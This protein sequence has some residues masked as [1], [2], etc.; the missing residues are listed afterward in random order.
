[1]LAAKLLAVEQHGLGH[2]FELFKLDLRRRRGWKGSAREAEARRVAAPA[3]A[4]WARLLLARGTHIAKSLGLARHAVADQLH[5]DDA[6]DL[7]KVLA[8]VALVQLAHEL[9]HENR[10]RVAR[11]LEQLFFF[12]AAR[13]R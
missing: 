3:R 6:A 4:R 12:C 2:R 1:V 11:Q 10:A 7:R 9:P 5:V 8:H 13:A